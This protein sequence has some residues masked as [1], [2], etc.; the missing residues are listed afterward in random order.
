MSKCEHGLTNA[1]CFVC[2][3][4]KYAAAP[5]QTPSLTEA[6]MADHHT[7]FEVGVV[8]LSAASVLVEIEEE[9]VRQVTA[10]GWTPEHDDEHDNRQLARA[11]GCY[12]LFSGSHPDPGDP[13]KYWPWDMEWWKPSEYRRNL[14]KAAAL[15]VA[16][17]ER[18]DRAAKRESS[19]D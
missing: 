8:H 18:L 3:S 2:A 11:A 17:V 13:P 9:R 5:Q 14:I 12:A 6:E 10:E 16:E 1:E 19:N 4:P 7:L 15:I